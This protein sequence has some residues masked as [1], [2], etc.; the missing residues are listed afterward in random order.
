MQCYAVHNCQ[1]WKPHLHI[2]THTGNALGSTGNA[3]ISTVEHVLGSTAECTNQQWKPHLHI[4]TG[5]GEHWSILDSTGKCI[6]PYWGLYWATLQNMHWSALQSS[7]VSTGNLINI[8]APTY[9]GVLLNHVNKNQTYVQHW[10]ALANGS[11]SEEK[12]VENIVLGIDIV[13]HTWI[14]KAKQ[15]MEH[16]LL[17]NIQTCKH[18]LL[19][20]NQTSLSTG[21]MTKFAI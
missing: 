14:L 7:L 2:F 19:L 8:F 9:T 10:R 3:L 4:N 13:Y 1:H 16:I 20:N 17:R 21:D 11:F 6:G 5:T 18:R 12:N 15:N